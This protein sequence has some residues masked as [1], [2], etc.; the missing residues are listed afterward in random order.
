MSFDKGF[1]FLIFLVC[2]SLHASN[3]TQLVGYNNQRDNKQA[4]DKRVSIAREKAV[5]PSSKMTYI[6]HEVLKGTKIEEEN[7]KEDIHID[8][9][10][11]YSSAH[12]HPPQS[13]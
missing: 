3:A 11:D 2:I 8:F 6:D 10:F 9:N 4:V 13:N 12:T 5:K 7:E 1:L